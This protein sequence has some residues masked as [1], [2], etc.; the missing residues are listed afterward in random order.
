MNTVAQ[1]VGDICAHHVW[2]SKSARIPSDSPGAGVTA[3]SINAGSE[4]SPVMRI[5]DCLRSEGSATMRGI[6][7]CAS[8]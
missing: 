4:R 5:N 2:K 6:I 1:V 3:L 7:K 8:L